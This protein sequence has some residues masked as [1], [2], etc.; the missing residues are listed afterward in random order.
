M[1]RREEGVAQR[2]VK[3][4]VVHIVQEEV[5][6]RQVERGVVNLLSNEP[7]F[8]LVLKLLLGLQQQRT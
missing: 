3:F 6:A 5:H 8:L 1:L 7:H 4:C 2:K